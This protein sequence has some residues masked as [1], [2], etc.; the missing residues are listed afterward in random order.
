MH[1]LGVLLM[2]A[3]FYLG[4]AWLLERYVYGPPDDK[5]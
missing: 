5:P 2:L 3:I 1:L 4:V